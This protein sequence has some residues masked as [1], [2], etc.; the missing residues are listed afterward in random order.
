MPSSTSERQG[1]EADVEFG[2]TNEP[3]PLAFVVWSHN[4]R[5]GETVLIHVDLPHLDE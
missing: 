4:L 2:P 1:Q 3:H 5:K